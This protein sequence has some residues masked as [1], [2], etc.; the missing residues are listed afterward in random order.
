MAARAPEFPL[1]LLG[2][3]TTEEKA[4]LREEL[5]AAGIRTAPVD[6]VDDA[7][8]VATALRAAAAP[9][10]LAQMAVHNLK[11]PLTSLLAALEM[12]ADGDLGPLNERQFRALRDMQ[13][14]GA[15][16]LDLIEDLLQLW[17]LESTALELSI[18]TIE[19]HQLLAELREEWAPAFARAGSHVHIEPAGQL[20][21]V[22]GDRGVLRRAF[23]NLLH[24][25]LVH[26]GE[27]V[28]VLLGAIPDNGHVRFVVADNGVG[29][30]PEYH[31]VIFQKFARLP[32][33]YPSGRRGTGLGLAFC[34]LAAAAHH[35]Q[36][37]VESEPGQGCRFNLR[38]PAA[39]DALGS[40]P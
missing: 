33:A 36:L 12:L 35:G 25:A 6:S 3:G 9:D 30:P 11:T 4:R 7:K 15:E 20:P 1:V 29:I 38:L 10:D 13:D 17:R 5:E 28:T 18:E 8:A 19:P 24:N 34:R 16:L 37:W 2:G 21:A 22:A 31:E 14:R 32:R 27:H 23:G 39:L 26:G 40:G